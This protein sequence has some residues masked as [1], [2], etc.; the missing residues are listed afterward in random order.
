MSGKAA[1]GRLRVAAVG[2]L[3]ALAIYLSAV[4]PVAAAPPVP[5]SRTFAPHRCRVKTSSRVQ[6]LSTAPQVMI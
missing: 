3:A 1:I 2:T 5:A 4:A 6:E